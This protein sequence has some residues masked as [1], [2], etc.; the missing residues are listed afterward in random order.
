MALKRQGK[1]AEEAGKLIQAAFEADHPV[2]GGLNNIP[3]SVKKAYA[4]R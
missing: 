2:W 4:E 1:S 3:Q